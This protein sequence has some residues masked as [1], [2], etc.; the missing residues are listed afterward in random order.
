MKQTNTRHRAGRWI[1]RIV[2]ALL[3]GLCL[4]VVLAAGL[5]FYLRAKTAL[6]HRF[7][8]REEPLRHPV[9]DRLHADYLPFTVQHI[10]PFYMFFFP[11]DRAQR[12]AM[13]N[14]TCSIDANGFRGPGPEA[15][16]E[17]KLAF[18]LG[19]SAAFGHYASSDATTITGYMNQMQ[20]AYLFVNAGVPSWV[21]WQ[22]LQRLQSQILTYKPDLVV[23]YDSMN[24]IAGA[25]T[26]WRLKPGFFLPGTPESFEDLYA[27]VGDIRAGRLYTPS[28]PW[29]E[30]LLPRVSK[31]I[32][33]RLRKKTVNPRL[34]KAMPEV[35]IR[36]AADSYV[37]NLNYM[38][39][40]TISIGG[41]FLAVY[42]PARRLHQNVPAEFRDAFRT[43]AYTTFL[44]ILLDHPGITFDSL[45]LT[46]FFDEMFS[47]VPCF[48]PSTPADLD[49][50][51]IF[52]DGG[53][54]YDAGNR[55]IAREILRHI[56][57]LETEAAISME[58]QKQDAVR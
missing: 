14:A 26:Y 8:S 51:T 53:H 45:N 22:E 36:Q 31:G 33:A 2:A 6:A 44:N 28:K 43:P 54:L 3:W 58:A 50:N 30:K 25:F 9:Y 57:I 19:G 1:G 32:R 11:Y 29:Y 5:E 38:H 10:N 7:S 34:Q 17:R 16:G 15:A 35:Y 47:Q 40:L 39:A 41:D 12:V 20:S 52:V 4:L 48:D 23:A 18:L 27:L 37:R 13:N 49:E 56:G 55:I 24:D 46:S 21:S 42:Q